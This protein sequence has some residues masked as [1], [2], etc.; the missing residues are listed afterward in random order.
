MA[1]KKSRRQQPKRKT[2]Q[3]NLDLSSISPKQGP[4]Y[5]HTQLVPFNGTKEEELQALRHLL[6][7]DGANPYKEPY[8]L[9]LEF[10]PRLR[11]CE[12]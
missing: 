2:T 11:I 7:S 5:P 8:N 4:V 10:G 12:P 3:T 1:N 6:P 9:N